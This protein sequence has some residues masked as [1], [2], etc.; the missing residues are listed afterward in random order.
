MS[1][2]AEVRLNQS[3][4]GAKFDHV[5]VFTRT[6]ASFILIGRMLCH[7]FRSSQTFRRAVEEH[8][9]SS[10]RTCHIRASNHSLRPFGHIAY[11][12]RGDTW[13]VDRSA[14]SHIYNL[15]GVSCIVAISV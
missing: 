7:S 14:G 12:R 8:S 3:R 13:S 11:E 15:C 5:T 4:F 6:A 2:T 10:S 9:L 1:H